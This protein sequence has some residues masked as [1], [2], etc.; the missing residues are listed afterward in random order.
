LIANVVVQVS[1]KH[2]DEPQM[3]LGLHAIF[4]VLCKDFAAT[5]ISQVCEL[6]LPLLAAKSQA[7]HAIAIGIVDHFTATQRMAENAS[8]T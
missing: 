4:Q 7:M 3:L 6:L 5:S 8:A 2:A 1:S